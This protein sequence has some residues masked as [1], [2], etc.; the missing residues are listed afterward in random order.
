MEKKDNQITVVEFTFQFKENIE[1]VW[2]LVRDL[3]LLTTLSA[4]QAFPIIPKKKSENSW[5][6]GSC[7]EG[8]IIGFNNFK[9]QCVQSE[10]FPFSKKIKWHFIYEDNTELWTKLTLFKN[11]SDDSTVL[12]WHEDIAE[13]YFLRKE[14]TREE[15]CNVK[16]LNSIDVLKKIKMILAESCVNLFQFEGCIIRGKMEDIWDFFINPTKLKKIAPLICFDVETCQ[17]SPCLKEGD[18]V[19]THF[20]DNN[21][22]QYSFV[23][24]IECKPKMNK[25]VLKMINTNE[26]R[27]K[28]F[29]EYTVNLIK[30]NNEECHLSAFHEFKSKISNETIQ[31]I[32]AQKKYALAN[33]KDFLENYNA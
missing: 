15:I 32:S 13:S 20:F 11:S 27:D 6:L 23:K 8:N 7:F 24:K 18:F 28:I 31:K 12:L 3:D 16:R 33:L 22:L 26:A 5:I 4:G 14:K 9:A 17:G 25:W 2:A 10:S 21:T 29:S 30:I 19:K 1:R